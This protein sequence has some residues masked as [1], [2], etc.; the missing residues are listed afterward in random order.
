MKRKL[1]NK[2]NQNTKKYLKFLKINE[3]YIIVDKTYNIVK[4]L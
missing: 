2:L 4:Y 1:K 3:M